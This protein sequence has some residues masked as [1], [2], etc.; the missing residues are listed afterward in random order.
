MSLAFGKKQNH[1]NGDGYLACPK[2]K[3]P[4]N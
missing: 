3:H 2:D 4:F 1:P